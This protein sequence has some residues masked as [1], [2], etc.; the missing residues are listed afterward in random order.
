MKMQL[1]SV[2]FLFIAFQAQSQVI[3]PNYDLA[4]R[5]L[6]PGV[7]KMVMLFMLIQC[8]QPGRIG[9]IFAIYC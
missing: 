3:L 8:L 7:P 5:E 1:L 4:G 2:F 6:P 9:S